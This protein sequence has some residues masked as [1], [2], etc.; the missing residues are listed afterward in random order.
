MAAAGRWCRGLGLVVV[1]AGSKREASGAMSKNKI[2][3][4]WQEYSAVGRRLL[5]T[6]FIAFKVPLK[7]ELPEG[8]LF[9]KIFTAGHE[10]PNAKNILTFKQ[11]VRTFLLDNV[12]NDKL[13]GV[14]CTHGVNR[15]GYLICRY[16]IDVDGMEPREA[17][18]LFNK[19]RGYPI[20]RQNY[21]QDLLQGPRRS[22]KGIDVPARCSVTRQKE[23]FGQQAVFTQRARPYQGKC[24]TPNGF[25]EFSQSTCPPKQ[26]TYPYQPV[27]HPG[28]Q[29]FGSGAVHQTVLHNGHTEAYSNLDYGRQGSSWRSSQPE[30]S[31]W[32]SQPESSRW[33][34]QPE[35]SRWSSQPESSRWSSQPE[36]SRWSSQPESSRWSSQPESSRWSSQP[37]SSRWSSQ[38]ESSRWS[39]QPESSRWSSQ[40]ESPWQNYQLSCGGRS[41]RGGKLNSGG[42][43]RFNTHLRWDN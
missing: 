42:R 21:I 15:T 37:E 8:L 25:R 24:R 41:N 16:L 32:S 1:V 13:V 4:R 20:E 29:R 5:G 2:P 28:R 33:S 31:R 39:S 30:S 22:N 10:V 38:P 19:S 40:P 6:R 12:D 17:I 23:Q 35:S 27:Q 26:S 14:H 18:N 11:A 3:D 36:S 9:E 34:S 7:K 43:D